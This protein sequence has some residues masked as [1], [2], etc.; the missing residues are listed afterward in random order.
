MLLDKWL[1]NNA[2]PCCIVRELRG[3]EFYSEWLLKA[4]NQC[5][6]IA[7]SQVKSVLD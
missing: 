7:H 6:L 5:L 3:G 1:E 4:A 2:T